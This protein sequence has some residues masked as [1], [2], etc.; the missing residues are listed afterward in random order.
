MIV[1]NP[2]G[3]LVGS[4]VA[5]VALFF[6][7][8]QR[9]RHR[10]LAD[11]PTSKVRGVFIGLVELKGSAESE[12]PLTS[13]LAAARCV[14]YRWTVEEHWRRTETES[15]T[16]SKGNRRTRVKT[17]SGWD[18]VASGGDST[19]FYLQDDTG[20]ILVHPKG[21]RV[22]R[23][24]MFD[25]TVS[26]GDP[27]YHGR[28]PDH[29]VRGSTGRR[30]FREEGIPLHA[31]LYLVG[32]ARERPDIVA[33]YISA[34]PATEFIISTRP[35]ESVRSGLA[36]GSWALW[37]LGLIAA[38]AGPYFGLVA[39][40]QPP[41]RELPVVLGIVVG[42]YLALW[43]AG[44][45]WM[46]HDSLLGLRE[47]VRQGWSLIDVQLKR[48]HDLLPRLAAAV[49][50][51]AAHERE[52]QTALADIRAQSQ[53]TRPGAPGPDF[54]GLAP[55]LR[56]VVERYPELRAAEGFAALERELIDTENRVAL[57]RAYYNDI[58]THYATR[59]E[60]VPDRWVA[61]LRK[62]APEPL[63]AATRFER[64]PVLVNLAQ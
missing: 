50:G 20:V 36:L 19:V 63:L 45:T 5:L 46:V 44:W 49:A 62:L 14:D 8:R 61:G 11:L 55:E 24:L 21:A 12:S 31:P 53:A 48:R 33:P 34:A 30:R 22:D 58:A 1:L 56:V 4:L 23:S 42:A 2:V 32:D 26:R 59:L 7:L 25:Q 38:P 18:T 16:D 60:I 3:P 41:P 35:E 29:S 43:A 52:V 54:D 10:L 51:L 13:Y 47:R 9:R 28:G 40:N 57:A 39:E 6:S 64:A 15:Y 27:L 17:T 37:L